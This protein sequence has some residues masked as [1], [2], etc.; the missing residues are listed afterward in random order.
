MTLAYRD[1]ENKNILV[2][3][4]LDLQ[5]KHLFDTYIERMFKRPERSNK[6]HFQDT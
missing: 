3:D 6:E 5:R 2:L 1:M 4:N